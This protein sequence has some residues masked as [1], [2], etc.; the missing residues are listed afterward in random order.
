MSSQSV[1]LR[2]RPYALISG[3]LLLLPLLPQ[4]RELKPLP[5]EVWTQIFQHAIFRDGALDVR[6]AQ[7][8]LTICKAFKVRRHTTE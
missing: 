1:I 8:L 6:L 5:S 3:H 2:P 4:R 7:V